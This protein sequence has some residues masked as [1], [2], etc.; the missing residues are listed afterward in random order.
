[1]KKKT[2]LEVTQ[3]MKQTKILI[4]ENLDGQNREKVLTDYGMRVYQ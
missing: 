1:M 2:C 3:F 4:N